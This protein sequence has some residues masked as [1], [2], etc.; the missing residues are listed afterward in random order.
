MDVTRFYENNFKLS[1]NLYE[2]TDNNNFDT[3]VRSDFRGNK[4]R[5]I[6]NCA[7]R[8][9]VYKYNKRVFR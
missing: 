8:Y 7:F 3:E 4:I 2:L 5:F 6:I 1:H 9:Y